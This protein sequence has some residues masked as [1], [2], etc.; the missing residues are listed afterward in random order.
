MTH[1]YIGWSAGTGS[2]YHRGTLNQNNSN[3]KRQGALGIF[4]YE[5]EMQS[6]L[7]TVDV[8]K[9]FTINRK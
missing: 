8:N 6:R 7:L 9:V 1:K 5:D 3:S 4:E 2:A